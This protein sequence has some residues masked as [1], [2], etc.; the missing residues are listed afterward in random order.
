MLD[1][2][3]ASRYIGFLNSNQA[4]AG[5][6]FDKEL[7][8]RGLNC[9]LPILRTKKALSDMASGEVLKIMATDPGAVRDFHAFSKQTGNALLLSD[10]IDD[11]FVF[12]MQKK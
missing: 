12:F 11:A 4:E 1:Y 7:D 2:G 3:L 10:S 5:M 8:A 9:P 6:Q